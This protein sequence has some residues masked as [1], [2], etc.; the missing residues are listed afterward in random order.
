MGVDTMGDAE[1][2]F[3]NFSQEVLVFCIKSRHLIGV[4]RCA[5]AS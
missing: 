2:G 3:G 4:Q 5:D 1:F